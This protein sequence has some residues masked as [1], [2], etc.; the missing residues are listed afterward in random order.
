MKAILALISAIVIGFGALIAWQRVDGSADEITSLGLPTPAE[1]VSLPGEKTALITVGE[2]D[3]ARGIG[4]ALEDEGVITSA[5]LFRALVGLMGL[6]DD[7]GAGEYEFPVNTPV[8]TVIE[9]MRHGGGLTLRFITI[10]EGLRLEEIGER[11]EEQNVVTA[12]DFMDAVEN[13]RQYDFAFLDDLPRGATLEGYLFPATYDMPEDIDAEGVVNVMLQGFEDQLTEEMLAGFENEG[14]TLHEAVTLASIVER[15]AVVARERP[16]IARV[17]LNRIANDMLLQAD[18]TTQYAVAEEAPAGID[19]FGWWKQELTIED[20]ALDSPYN[21]YVSAGLPPGPIA[22][23]GTASLEA[24][25]EPDDSDDML[26][27]VACGDD[28]HHE[29][30]ATLAEHEANVARCRDGG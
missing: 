10:P 9:Q 23:P 12:A 27:F 18:P 13:V 29:F 6:E 14:L 24:V 5:R 20:L 28:G 7:L 4:E 19:E 21:T 17:Y 16:L 22:A 15:E 25:A 1:E 11:L 2:G 30:A 26:F 3:T 8:L